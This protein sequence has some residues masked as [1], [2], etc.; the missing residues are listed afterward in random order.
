MSRAL[1]AITALLVAV[2]L[3]ILVSSGVAQAQEDSG[4]FGIRIGEVPV[5]LADNPRAAT[6]IIDNVPP[7]K[8]LERQ[9]VVSSTMAERTTFD[10]YVG[11]AHVNDEGYQAEPRGATNALTT[12]TSLDKTEVTLDPGQ[13]EVVTVSVDVPADAPEIEQYALI[14]MSTKVDENNPDAVQA[15]SRVGI[16]MYLSVGTGDGPRPS[17]S[18]DSLLPIRLGDGTA[19]VK[20]VLENSGARAVEVSGTLDLTDGPGGLSVPAVESGGKTIPADSRGELIIEVPNSGEFPAGP[21]SA[22]VTLD[23]GYGKE[24]AA[25]EISFP[26]QGEGEPVPVKGGLSA[27]AWIALGV[28]AALLVALLALWRRRSSTSAA[29]AA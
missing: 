9:I 26:D 7:G 17:F 15:V 13:E 28:G 22:S 10:L 21:W 3:A 8:R 20:A 25:A 24:T 16:R 2:V 19:A 18:I 11:A 29:D 14:W 6:Y 27:A 4:G 12:W 1:S 23:S 5:N